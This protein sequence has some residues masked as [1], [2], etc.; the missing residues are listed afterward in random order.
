MVTHRDLDAGNEARTPFGML[1]RMRYR[2]SAHPGPSCQSRLRMPSRIGTTLPCR[3]VTHI[4]APPTGCCLATC[5]SLR[6]SRTV[7]PRGDYGAR[8]RILLH[9]FHQFGHRC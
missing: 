5:S 2:A 6:T 9:Y 3:C 8:R 1:Q 7:E 4:A